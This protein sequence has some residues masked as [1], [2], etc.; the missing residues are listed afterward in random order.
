MGRKI[1]KAGTL[2]S[3]IHQR[4]QR[5]F[6]AM[7]KESGIGSLNP[8][9]SK[10]IFVLWEAG[11]IPIS[12]LVQKTALRKSTLT[13]MLSRL[14]N[15]M[16]IERNISPADRRI[17]LVSLSKKGSDI[18]TACDVLSDRM[19]RVF[20]NGMTENEIDL[21]EKNLTHVLSNLEKAEA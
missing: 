12:T 20:Y 7:M 6:S 5:I 4:S 2:I 19:L 14:E 9:Q 21:F 13:S 16:F 17:T 8:A 1:R 18:I 10:I 3:K 15:K 11:T